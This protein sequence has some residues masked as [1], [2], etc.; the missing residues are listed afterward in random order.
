MLQEQEVHNQILL[1]TI[2]TPTARM[3]Q[4]P[5]VLQ[6]VHQVLPQVQ[7]RVEEE[8]QGEIRMKSLGKIIAMILSI[9]GLSSKATAKKK[10]K[11]KKIDLQVKKIQVA[12]AKVQKRKTQVKKAQTKATKKRAP[13]KVT[14]AKKAASSLKRR[15]KK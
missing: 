13:K 11:V 10:A 12:K 8:Q 7:V 4:A 5:E 2:L 14:S 9:L 1:T 15:A 6:E 3:Y